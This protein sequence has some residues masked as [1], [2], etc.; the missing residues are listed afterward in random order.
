MENVRVEIGAP[1]PYQHI[2]DSYEDI[3]PRQPV[4]PIRGSFTDYSCDPVRTPREIAGGY[5]DNRGRNCDALEEPRASGV[6]FKTTFAD[7]HCTMVDIK[8]DVVRDTRRG[9]AP[10]R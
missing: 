3:D 6:C 1:R 10:P 7:W 2:Q 5:A 8:A 9:I 4:Y